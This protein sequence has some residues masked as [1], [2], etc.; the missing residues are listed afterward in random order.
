MRKVFTFLCRFEATIQSLVEISQPVLHFQNI[1]GIRLW[2]FFYH[3][4]TCNLVRNVE[5]QKI[6]TIGGVCSST[7]TM[8]SDGCKFDI[9]F[10]CSNLLLNTI[11]TNY[12]RLRVHWMEECRMQSIKEFVSD[13]LWALN[14]EN[15]RVHT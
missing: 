11:S 9:K 8:S 14:L 4:S 5:D 10:T 7:S 2:R 6:S 13:L 1:W 12:W 3:K 15:L